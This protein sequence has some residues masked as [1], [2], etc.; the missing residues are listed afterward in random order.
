[1]LPFF[2]N[3]FHSNISHSQLTSWYQFSWETTDHLEVNTRPASQC[4]IPQGLCA[5]ATAP[6][7]PSVKRN[8]R[9]FQLHISLLANHE[10]EAEAEP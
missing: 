1:M 5:S 4:P 2:Y 9:T 8:G 7:N 3:K 6:A 10:K